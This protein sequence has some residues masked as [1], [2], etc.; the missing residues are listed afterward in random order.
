MV[1]Y[2]PI[3]GLL[4]SCRKVYILY[5]YMIRGEKYIDC[6]GC[7]ASKKVAPEIYVLGQFYKGFFIP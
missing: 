5:V 3:L 4:Q 2:L 7:G 1:Q 6:S